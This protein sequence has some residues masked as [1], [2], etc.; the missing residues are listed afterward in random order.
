MSE[1]PY[2]QVPRL[3]HKYKGPELD[4]PETACGQ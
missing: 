4:A 3:V 1:L 2:G